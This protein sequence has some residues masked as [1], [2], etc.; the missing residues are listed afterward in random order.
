MSATAPRVAHRI[1]T[2]SRSTGRVRFSPVADPIVSI[3]IPV[4]NHVADTVACLRALQVNTTHKFFEVIVC[5]D[6]SSDATREVLHAIKGLKVIRLDQN[7]GFLVAIA[8]AIEAARGTYLLMLNNDAEVQPGW[9][10]ALLDVAEGDAT[11]GAVGSKLIFPDGRLQEAGSLV[12]N[13]GSAWNLDMA[14]TLL[15]LPST[16]DVRSTTARPRRF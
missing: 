14:A 10:T 16:T 9:L 5:D 4:H 7:V 8:T 3:V 2:S 13:D 12:W 11:V 15:T 6:A 1:T